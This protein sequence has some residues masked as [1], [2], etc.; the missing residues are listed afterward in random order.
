MSE[1]ELEFNMRSHAWYIGYAPYENPRYS[2]VVLIEH[3]MSGGG[4][5]APIAARVLR[6]MNELE[7]F[8]PK[9]LK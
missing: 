2:F 8:D 3:G 4:V 9:N 7:Y 6:K 5:A 1:T